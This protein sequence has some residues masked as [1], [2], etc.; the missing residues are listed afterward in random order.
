METLRVTLEAGVARITLDRPERHNAFNETVL[1]ELLQAVEGLGRDP[2]ARVLVLE[3]AGPSFS[4]GADLEWMRA[5]GAA[6]EEENRASALRMAALFQAL[7]LCPRP[8][9]ARVHGPALGG[10]CGLVC[11][12]DL[13]VAGPEASFGFT[14]VRLGLL[15][16]VIAPYA[17]RRLG[18]SQARARF[19]TGQRFGAE[20][21]LRIGMV[22]ALAD[23]LDA[24]VDRV[25]QALLAGSPE[26]QAG[27]KALVRTL[28]RL[29]R[30]LQQD[31]T[32]EQA[33]R[34]RASE[35]GREGMSAF[36]ERRKPSWAVR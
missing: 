5:M 3:G 30:E 10:G 35:E 26:A 15:P 6:S 11:A 12:V 13:A 7:D 9:V 22:H 25:V 28:T 31:H 23:D 34:S 27:C 16:A 17:I 24:E 18:E 32:V 21:A 19:L 20:E 2:A 14:E 33:T 4:A 8:V 1:A 36:L 29:P